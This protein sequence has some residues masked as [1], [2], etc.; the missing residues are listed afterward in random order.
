MAQCF[1]KGAIRIFLIPGLKEE[2]VILHMKTRFY[3]NPTKG[4]KDDKFACSR[5]KVIH[6]GEKVAWLCIWQLSHKH[7][8][9]IL[10]AIALA[11]QSEI[12]S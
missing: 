10:L 7:F 1:Q 9:Q 5:K 3:S 6:E 2:M 11:F 4:T 12:R 8:T